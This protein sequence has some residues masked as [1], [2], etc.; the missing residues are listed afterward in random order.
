[1]IVFDLKCGEAG[2][3]FEGWFRSSEDFA[4]QQQSGLLACPQ[5]GSADVAKAA[6]APAVARKG[7]Q[8]AT[9]HPDRNAE[10]PEQTESTPVSNAPMPEAVQKALETL[11]KAQAKALEKSRWVGNRFA[12]DAR[13]MHYGE[14]EH[15]TIHGAASAEDAEALID[16]GIAIAP[17]P[18]PIAPPD[19]QN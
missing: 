11:A 19:E 7:N 8:V 2:H 12:E 18:F 3:R 13:A 1:M 5:C 15:E 17:L 16:E 9:S 4:N 6:M 10:S 14:R